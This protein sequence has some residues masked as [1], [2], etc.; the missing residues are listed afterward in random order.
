VTARGVHEQLERI[1][2][3]R[4]RRRCDRAGLLGSLV[5]HDDIA[6]F[7]RNAKAGEV[8]L[9]QLVLVGERL[10]VLLLDEA[11]LGGLL[12]QS[13][14]RR[15]VMQMNRVAQCYSFRSWWAAGLAPRRRTAASLRRR[16]PTEL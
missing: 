1:E 5:A 3:A 16:H 8:V 14:D 10:N 9:G 13:L 15:E 4:H 2:R 12:E 11:A 6:L 7:E